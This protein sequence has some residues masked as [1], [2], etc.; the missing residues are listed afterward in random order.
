M[1]TIIKKTSKT[2]RLQTDT[3]SNYNY[4]T[5]LTTNM[6]PLATKPICLFSNMNFRE[7]L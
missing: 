2:H 7:E 1:V 5:I 3:Y 6:F 4:D